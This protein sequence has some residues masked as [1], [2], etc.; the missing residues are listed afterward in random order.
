L[1][2]EKNGHERTTCK[3]EK[4]QEVISGKFRDP[5]V[6]TDYATEEVNRKNTTIKL[7]AFHDFIAEII[8]RKISSLYTDFYVYHKALLEMAE[9]DSLVQCFEDLFPVLSK[10]GQQKI[11]SPQAT[12]GVTAAVRRRAMLN[13]IFEQR[14][15]NSD[16]ALPLAETFGLAFY[17]WGMGRKAIS[18]M[19]YFGMCCSYS[20]IHNVFK[21]LTQKA[22]D[23]RDLFR[24]STHL[25]GNFDNF[26]EFLPEK[27]QRSAGP[28]RMLKLTARYIRPLLKY[29]NPNEVY[30]PVDEGQPELTFNNQVIP[31]VT[32]MLPYE[33]FATSKDKEF[34]IKNIAEFSL[35]TSKLR[36]YFS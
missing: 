29:V 12:N 26:Q 7:K 8:N 19:C 18:L 14:Q 30:W 28:A 11:I 10:I 2:N 1:I 22:P 5:Q 13:F 4:L 20:Q 16:F 33:M 27:V 9:I 36:Q 3:L 35:D 15:R 24:P 34:L 32:T 31:A 25:M 17:G 23:V 6:I 21:K